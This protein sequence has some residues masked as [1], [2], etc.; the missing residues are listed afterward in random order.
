MALLPFSSR[1]ACQEVRDLLNAGGDVTPDAF[2][3][4]REFA[5][6]DFAVDNLIAEK[7]QLTLEGRSGSEA[8]L[9]LSGSTFIALRKL[10]T[11]VRENYD[12]W[13]GFTLNYLFDLAQQR[14][15]EG[16]APRAAGERKWEILGAGTNTR[17][18]L[19]WRMYSRGQVCAVE[20]E[21]GSFSFPNMV[22]VGTNSHDFWMSHVLGTQ[23]GSERPFSQAFVKFQAE[24]HLPTDPLRAFVRDS[25]NRPK[26]TI[27]THLMSFE[28]ASS[29][30]ERAFEQGAGARLAA[31][32]LNGEP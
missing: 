19:A 3:E 29:H 18:I 26:R 20:R 21:D 4:L 7:N 9:L 25:V 8:E 2:I 17:E 6:A 31:D 11:Q 30:F 23:T 32:E 13:R 15:L 28:E 24:G 27:A 22:E 1:Q 10:P 5:V 16:K 12:F 14:T